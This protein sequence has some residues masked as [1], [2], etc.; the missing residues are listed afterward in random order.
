MTKIKKSVKN[1]KIE[2]NK[3]IKEKIKNQE[4]NPTIRK[5]SEI[6]K[7]KTLKKI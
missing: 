5:N 3:K 7:S 4:R 2:N 6:T 1:P